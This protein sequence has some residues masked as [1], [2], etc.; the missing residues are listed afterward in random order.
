MPNPLL[1][2]VLAEEDEGEGEDDPDI[3]ALCQDFVSKPNPYRNPAPNV[4]QIVGDTTVTIG[5]QAGCSSAQNETTIAVNPS[6][7]RNI[8]A[9]ANDY[10]VFV[11]REQRNDSTGWAYTS[12]DGGKTWKNQVLPGL[13]IAT[14]ATGPLTAMDAAG[15][16]VLA[17]GPRNTVYYGNIVFSRGAPAAGGTEAPSGIVV[18]VSRDGGAHWARP[19]IIQLDGTDATGTPTPTTFFNDKIWLAADKTSGRVY[20]TWTRFADTPEGDYLES[21]IVVSASTDFGRSFAPF[22]RV[23][24]TL[25]GVRRRAHSVLAGLQP[26]GHPRRHVYIAY[27]GT[28]CATLACDGFDDRDVTV[29]ARST[30]HGRTFSALDRRHQLR[31]PAQRGGRQPDPDRGELPD[32][33]LPAARVRPGHRPAGAELER[34]PQRPLHRGR[35]VDP[36]QRRHHRGLRHAAAGTGRSG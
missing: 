19:T 14:G 32:Q 16:P 20:V 11:D 10:R 15:D 25:D 5:S 27:E 31:L 21:P 30:D 8:V 9:G 24:T 35:R 29:V 4:D 6:N 26:A 3:S 17:F 7:P 23:D 28:E 34:R 1:K 33:Q 22:T 36:D 18:S 2:E 12:F 13:T